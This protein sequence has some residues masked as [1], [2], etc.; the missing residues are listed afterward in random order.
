MQKDDYM[1]LGIRK[2]APVFYSLNS[3]DSLHSSD[4]SKNYLTLV[5]QVHLPLKG[6]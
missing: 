2:K 4:R 6:Y 1:Q 3:E 5:V